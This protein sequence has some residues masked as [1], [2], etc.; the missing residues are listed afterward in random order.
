MAPAIQDKHLE[1]IEAY[2]FLRKIPMRIHV[3][4]LHGGHIA[5]SATRKGD[6]E[7]ETTL[8]VNAS[9]KTIS[10][11][12]VAL[13]RAAQRLLIDLSVCAAVARDKSFEIS[14]PGIDRLMS[15]GDMDLSSDQAKAL[16]KAGYN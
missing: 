13:K 7:D 14:R 4:A 10:L 3:T 1:G 8:A 9:G 11:A 12:L 16:E 6:G 5:V 15:G 2:E